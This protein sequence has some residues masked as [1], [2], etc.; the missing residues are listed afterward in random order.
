[1]IAAARRGATQEQVLAEL[2]EIERD[3]RRVVVT[4][5]LV[6]CQ[7]ENS[8]AKVTDW[9]NRHNKATP[10]LSDAEIAGLV[11]PFRSRFVFS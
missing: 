11:E 6:R 1:M 4:D 10:L 2:A 9:I 5:L 7:R 3:A 8:Y